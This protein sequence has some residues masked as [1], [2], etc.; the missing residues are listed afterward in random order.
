MREKKRARV[1]PPGFLIGMELEERGWSQKDFAE[2]LGMSEQFVSGLIKGERT[3]TIEVARSVGKAFGTSAEVW[4][5]LE[6]KYR[7]SLKQAEEERADCALEETTEMRAEA[8]SRLPV[9]EL[10]KRGLISRKSRNGKGVVRE[11]LSALGLESL[12]RIPQAAPM[13][14]RASNAWTPSERGLAA[15][16]LLA[17]KEAAAQKV[18][19]FSRERLSATL[20]S[21]F[22]TSVNVE[23]IPE[24]PAWLAKN[25]IAFVYLPHFEKTYLDGATFRQEGKPV[26]GLTLRHDR[27]D[28]FWFTLAHE[29]GHIVL[30]HEEEFFDTTEGPERNLGPKEKEADEFARENMVPGAEFEAFKRRC[31][32][33]FPPEA[34]VEFSRTIQRHPALVVG[35]L[36]HDGLVSWGSHGAL[37]PKVRELLRK[38]R[39]G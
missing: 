28:N 9:A 7:L 12:D 21:L 32:K 27:L 11:L 19:V 24:V 14:L 26:V 35:R 29:L 1:N 4:M 30:G 6:A 22:Q 8:Y 34:I 33:S 36:R 13:F 3:L 17:R 25:G 15:W 10:R 2:I 31:R 39:G 18:G 16:F 38:N 37:V 5:N 23:K 20:P